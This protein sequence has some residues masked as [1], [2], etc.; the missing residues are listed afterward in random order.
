MACSSGGSNDSPVVRARR[1]LDD[2]DVVVTTTTTTPPPQPVTIAFAGDINFEGAMATRLAHDPQTAI[3]PFTD[4][5]TAA[6]LAVGNLE[7]AV[8]TGGTPENK[9]FTFQAPPS[10]IDALRAGGFDVVSMANNHGRDFG[11]DGLVE[12]LAVKDAQPD[13]FIIGIGHNDAE[14]YAPFTTTIHGQRIAVIGA[15]Q[16][17]DEELI[18]AWTATPTHPGLASAKRVDAL[19]AAVQ[20]ARANA[21]TVVVFLHWGIETQRLSERRAADPRAAT[22]RTRAP[23]SSSVATRTG[24][25]ARECS[26]PRSWATAWATSTSPR[27]A[28]APRRPASSKSR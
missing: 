20:Q 4:V 28:P 21:D 13:H 15:T 19:V 1:A 9:D 10:A 16:V 22:R 11:P 2:V 8:G 26:A 23:T 24:C 12:S 6:D 14:A 17:L 3:G 27:S 7:T 5:L 25:R 18:T